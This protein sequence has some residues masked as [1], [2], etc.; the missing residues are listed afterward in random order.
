MTDTRVVVTGFDMITPVGLDAAASFA[1]MLAGRSGVRRASTLP[2]GLRSQVAAEVPGDPVATR[3]CNESAAELLSPLTRGA[4]LGVLAGL[5]AAQHA[6][7]DGGEPDRTGV[8]MGTSSAHTF[9]L[10]FLD[11]AQAY[12]DQAGQWD[13]PRYEVGSAELPLP[14]DELCNRRENA[15]SSLAVL[16]QA[17]GPNRTFCST[18][19]SGSQA[20]GEAARLIQE[21]DA[22]IMLAGGCDSLLDF[23]IFASFDMLS[24]LSSRY[25]D[26]PQIA[27]RPFDRRR[28]GF[29]MGEA[30]AAVVLESLTHARERGAVIYAE[31]A[32]YGTSCDAYRITDS[33]PDGAGAQ[34]AMAAALQSARMVPED[35]DYINAHGTGTRI[36]DRVETLAIKKAFGGHAH[37]VPVSSVKSMTGHSIGG[38]G[39]LEFVTCVMALG[40]GQIPP[41][42][43]YQYPDPE[44]DL[45]YVPNI[46]REV[47]LRTAMSNS[48][49][50]GGQNASLIARRWDG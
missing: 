13:Q 43:N 34:L 7:L 19:A 30:G 15:A 17:G 20:I 36:N 27:C 9:S 16:C 31:L 10:D 26:T 40:A 37:Q 23:V 22:D 38:A 46:S 44:C 28:D 25:S 32:G 3:N 18:C 49:G 12:L 6:G 41:T 5:G 48:F 29:V 11:V 39:A 47:P 24:A 2:P 1:A 35:V 14:A 50:F 42:I 21:G 8:C 45:D 33:A 4:R